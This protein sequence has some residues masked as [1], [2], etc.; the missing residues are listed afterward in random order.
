MPIWLEM[1]SGVRLA[2]Y[3]PSLPAL[4][5]TTTIFPFALL[6][7]LTKACWG[8]KPF[9]GEGF[10]VGVNKACTVTLLPADQSP[11]TFIAL[12]EMLS[13]PMGHMADPSH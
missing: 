1:I 6:F 9:E 10:Q 5:A 13:M 7:K 11:N 3:A 12:L 8:T 2:V 4:A